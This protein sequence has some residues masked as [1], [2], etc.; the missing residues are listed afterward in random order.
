MQEEYKVYGKRLI[1]VL[2]RRSVVEQLTPDD[3]LR[4]RA[5]F[6]KTHKSLVS[7]KGDIRKIKAFFNF[8]LDERHLE[9]AVRYGQGFKVPSATVLRRER[10]RKGIR[11]FQADQ[12]RSL[13][14]LAKA[15]MKAMILLGINC[16]FGNND[17]AMLS[18]RAVELPGGW[19]NFTRPKT[20][21]R[22]H[23][24]L[25]PETVEALKAVLQQRKEA[26]DP[27]Y[28]NR[29]FITCK[30]EP[31]TP[32]YVHDSPISK[33]F[34]KLLIDAHLDDCPGFYGLRHTF[35]TIALKTK[36]RDAVRVMMGH[37][38]GANDML[39]V[40]N[41]EDVDEERL[42]IVSNYVHNWLFKQSVQ[43]SAN[44]E[45][46]DSSELVAGASGVA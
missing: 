39:A 1:L 28:K 30:L 11:M 41:E 16:G 27:T 33:E 8:A 13:L 40:Y 25:W 37:A 21:S 29:V 24:P 22:R 36:D 15:Q 38:A 42:L 34:K 46:G 26:R 44:V 43:S 2:G 23:N 18:K 32:K 14:S 6:Q 4:L 9:R 5:D 31:W 17:C 10:E 35:A 12:I 19:V 3:F 20:S 45:M 7:I